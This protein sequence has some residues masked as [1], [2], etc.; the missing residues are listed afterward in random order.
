MFG[1]RRI[2][3]EF[4]GLHKSFKIWK[5]WKFRARGTG[6]RLKILSGTPSLASTACPPGRGRRTETRRAHSA[7]PQYFERLLVRQ[8]YR[9]WR[10]K[11]ET[12]IQE[13][14]KMKNDQPKTFPKGSNVH[15]KSSPNLKKRCKI[16]SGKKARINWHAFQNP[17]TNNPKSL[18]IGPRSFKNQSQINISL[19]NTNKINPNKPRRQIH[20]TTNAQPLPTWSQNRPKVFQNGCQGG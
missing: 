14:R 19:Q 13:T 18:N 8:G 9:S 3:D 16:P 12:M 6:S 20:P 5:I 11:V 10:P 2:F 4:W 1:S 7:G 17:L 15:D